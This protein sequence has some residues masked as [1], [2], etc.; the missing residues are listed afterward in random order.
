MT[1]GTLEGDFFDT[2]ITSEL[3]ALGVPA[4]GTAM[5][6]VSTVDLVMPNCGGGQCDIDALSP[7]TPP[8]SGDNEGY[9]GTWDI[10]VEYHLEGTLDAVT[11]PS[12]HGGTM[13]FFFNDF[14]DDSNDRKILTATV[15]GSELSIADL[16]VFFDVTF[17]EA[18]FL[19]IDNGTG[20]FVD[21]STLGVGEY[22]TF[23]LDT[24][25]FPPIPTADQLLLVGDNAIRQASLD[26][27]ISAK[28]PEPSSVALLSLGLLG[29]AA[30][31]RKIS[32]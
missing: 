25:V 13:E 6:G 32:I 18:G 7:I 26:G 3:T 2:N 20:T 5:D 27:S 1:D 23:A 10:Q 17:A 14:I 8:L 30:V 11:G 16:N 21:A 9:L 15:T 31:S 22:A 28:V 24:N 4:S 19:W 29:F 12:Y